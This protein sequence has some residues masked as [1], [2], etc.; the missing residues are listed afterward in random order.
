[1][2]GNV[3][4]GDD[5]ENRFRIKG[6][7][8]YF[9]AKDSDNFTYIKVKDGQSFVLTNPAEE[10]QDDLTKQQLL[11]NGDFGGSSPWPWGEK[12][13]SG[14]DAAGDTG[15]MPYSVDTK[16]QT[17]EILYYAIESDPHVTVWKETIRSW[18]PS[19]LHN[20]F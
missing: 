8:I 2:K 1:M 18:I 19:A 5:T 6:N 7:R 17:A 10:A 13:W 20:I 11:V 14:A 3:D 4:A 16:N 12:S 15:Y 9:I